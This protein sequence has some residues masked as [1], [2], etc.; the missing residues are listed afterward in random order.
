VRVTL[1]F[2]HRGRPVTGKAVDLIGVDARGKPGWRMTSGDDRPL[3]TDAAGA[4]TFAEVPEGRYAVFVEVGDWEVR[5]GLVDVAG[6]EPMRLPV[7]LGPHEARVRVLDGRGDP[8]REAGVS[9]WIDGRDWVGVV[10][11]DFGEVRSRTG[12]YEVPFLVKG[13]YRV[14]VNVGCGH[15]LAAPFEVGVG[16]PPEVV[17]RMDPMGS[18]VVRVTDAAGDPVREAHVRALRVSDGAGIGEDT[19]RKGRVRF[20]DLTTGKW[21]VGLSGDGI[22]DFRG[23]PREVEVRGFEETLVELTR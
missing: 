5:C 17:V 7:A 10:P 3:R 22:D 13:S 9:L 23:E 12:V 14:C 19:N 1:V 2:Q 18:I 8:V 16:D 21:R 11:R 20:G 15:A 6:K 4:I